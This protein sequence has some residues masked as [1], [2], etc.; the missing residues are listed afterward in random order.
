MDAPRQLFIYW[1]V[2]AADLAAARRAV[3]ELQ[4]RLRL[5][6]PAVQPSLLLRDDPAGLDEATLMEIYASHDG[7][8][9][10]LQQH[11]EVLCEPATAR[12]RRGPRH[13]EV[14]RSVER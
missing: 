7:I 1:R 11:I 3:L 10:A 8:D 2:A 4:Q 14:F 12:W 9:A 5:Q 6:H 13:V